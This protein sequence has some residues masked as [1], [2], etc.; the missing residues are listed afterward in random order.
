MIDKNLSELNEMT[1]IPLMTFDKLF[2]LIEENQF[3]NETDRKIAEKIIK[4]ER[5]WRISLDSLN[6]FIIILEKEVGGNVTK[7]SLNKLLKKYN[8][9]I[10]QYTW[11]AESVCYLLD[12]FDLTKETE[13]RNIFNKLTEKVKTE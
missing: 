4:A 3:E 11:E 8:R 13:L 9:N 7:T 5:D 1:E 12:I 6:D 2:D 10:A